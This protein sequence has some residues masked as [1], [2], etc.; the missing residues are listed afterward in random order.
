MRGLPAVDTDALVGIL[1][2]L[3]RLALERPD[4]AA[5]DINPLVVDSAQ[6][7]AVDALVLIGS[8]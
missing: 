7:V 1:L 3:S 6:P 8:P 5:V 4:I 2:A